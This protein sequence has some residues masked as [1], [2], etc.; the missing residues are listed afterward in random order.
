MV[1]IFMQKQSII[2][3]KSESNWNCEW[4][5]LVYLPPERKF[6]MQKM[7]TSKFLSLE[8]YF[9]NILKPNCYKN[10]DKYEK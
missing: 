1:I 5:L 10:I 7:L 9:L 8:K 6:W 3:A 2:L 4:M